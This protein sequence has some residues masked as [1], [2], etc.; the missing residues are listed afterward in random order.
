MTKM[1]AFI[2]GLS[3]FLINLFS[4]SRILRNVLRKAGVKKEVRW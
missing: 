1:I 2:L 3:I 4:L